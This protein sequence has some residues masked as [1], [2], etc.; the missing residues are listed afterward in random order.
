MASG[1]LQ[2][3]DCSTVDSHSETDDSSKAMNCPNPIGEDSG[4][5][6]TGSVDDLS[7]AELHEDGNPSNLILPSLPVTTE[8]SSRHCARQDCGDVSFSEGEDMVL[9]TPSTEWA[10]TPAN[11]P[12]QVSSTPSRSR[13][14]SS[15]SCASASS[16]CTLT[17]MTL[18]TCYSP[19]SV[20][21]VNS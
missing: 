4:Y 6:S 21:S 13:T 10:N 14:S 2:N 7:L 15:V 9:S 5:A 16:E 1:D 17:P 8:S 20:R 12:R 3:N 11:T 18:T 19:R